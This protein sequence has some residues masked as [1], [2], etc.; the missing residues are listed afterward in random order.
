MAPE[1]TIF[2]LSSAPGRAGVAVLRVSG[3][4]AG[5]ALVAFAGT[6][7]PARHARLAGRDEIAD[8]IEQDIADIQ[9]PPVVRVRLERP[10]LDSQ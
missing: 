2:A 3:P 4:G 6:C 9:T 7:P 1:D 8:K 10:E 5:P